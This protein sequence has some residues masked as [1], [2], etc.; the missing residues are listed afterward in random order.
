MDYPIDNF[1]EVKD[2]ILRFEDI[3][4]FYLVIVLKRK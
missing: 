1:D 4:D 3:G 2:N